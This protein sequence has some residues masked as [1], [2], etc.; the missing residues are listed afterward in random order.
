MFG[1]KAPTINVY[2]SSDPLPD[3]IQTEVERLTAF[4]EAWQKTPSRPDTRSGQLEAIA[5]WLDRIDDAWGLDDLRSI[6]QD[7]RDIAAEMGD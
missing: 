6:Q 3:S 1:R 4:I 7:L 5:N 2:V